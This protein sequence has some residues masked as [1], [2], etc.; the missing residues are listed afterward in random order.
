ML[1]DAPIQ[2]IP[3]RYSGRGAIDLRRCID[4]FE[5][6]FAEIVSPLATRRKLL[7][8]LCSIGTTAVVRDVARIVDALD[9]SN[10]P[11]NWLGVSYGTVREMTVRK[12]HN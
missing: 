6:R 12:P 8:N 9:G 10:A 4:H 3:G 7:T 5:R 11:I 2:F 1:T